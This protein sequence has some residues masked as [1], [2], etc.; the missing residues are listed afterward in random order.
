MATCGQAATPWME[1]PPLTRLDARAL[2][3]VWVK[4]ID[5]VSLGLF[6]TPKRRLYTTLPATMD[7]LRP[8]TAAI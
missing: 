2:C 1:V 8:I 5:L 7:T 6:Q 4:N 3:L